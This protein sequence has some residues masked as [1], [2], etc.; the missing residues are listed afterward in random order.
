[1]G[2]FFDRRDQLQQ[3]RN[4]L[5]PGE[6]LSAVY[7]VKGVGTG[8]VGI[9]SL[10]LIS[11]DQALFRKTRSMLSLPYSKIIA[12]KAREGVPS[13][14]GSILGTSKLMVVTGSRE[15]KFEFRSNERATKAYHLILQKMLQTE[16]RSI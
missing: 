14:L 2:E 16:A 13:I 7:D 3:I 11:M 12:L 10:R 15:W 9:T 1:M 5:L 8:F 6:I 4:M